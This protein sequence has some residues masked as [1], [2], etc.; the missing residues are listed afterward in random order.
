M[1]NAKLLSRK[2]LPCQPLPRP[3]HNP[4]EW[5]DDHAGVGAPRAPQWTERGTPAYRRISLA[6]FLAGFATFSLIYAVQPLLPHLVEEF[7]VSPSAGS[8]ALSLTTGCLAFAIL[9]A[10]AISETV[11]RRALMFGSMCGAAILHVGSAIA[12]DW[13]MLLVLRAL[14][15]LVLGGVPAVAMAYLA[16]EIHPKALGTAMGLYVGGT[17]FGAMLGRIGAGV[18]TEYFSWRVASG[19]IGVL[20]LL[21][22]LGF[23]A[24]LPPSRNFFPRTAGGMLA[25]HRETWLKHLRTPGLPLLFLT[26]FLALGINVTMFNYLTF[27]LSSAPFDLTPAQIGA[28][29]L[30]YLLGAIASTLAG[31]LADRLG[32]SPILLAGIATMAAGTALTLSSSLAG[33]IAG[34]IASTIGFFITHSVASGW[35]GRLAVGS[36]GH[37]SSLYLLAYYVGS[38]V[39]GTVGGWFWAGGGWNAVAGLVAI[40]LAVA[41]AAALGLGRIERRSA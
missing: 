23:F 29:F 15:G 36:K 39:M 38:S 8:L 11:S 33:V 16:E 34:V 20:G 21:A 14:E 27:R 41:L 4:R 35:V 25:H 2:P 13:H 32:R 1:I 6:L 31:N 12:P 19:G 30:V 24:L 10:G 7:G 26:G 5:Q 3:N 22:S 28:I 9:C 37:A 17:A 18:V 40:M